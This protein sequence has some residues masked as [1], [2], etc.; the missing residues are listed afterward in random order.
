MLHSQGFPAF[1]AT[2]QSAKPPRPFTWTVLWN[3]CLIRA[4]RDPRVSWTS[5]ARA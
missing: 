4:C 3:E 5:Y 2:W 1:Q